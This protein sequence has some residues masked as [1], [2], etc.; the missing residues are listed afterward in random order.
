MSTIFLAY[1]TITV[2]G[3]IAMVIRALSALSHSPERLR[4]IL[5]LP[6][7]SGIIGMLYSYLL[8]EKA[9]TGFVR[10]LQFGFFSDLLMYFVGLNILTTVMSVPAIPW[11]LSSSSAKARIWGGVFCLCV[12]IW[13]P[14]CQEFASAPQH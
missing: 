5:I 10:L 7:L 4:A 6:M 3:I 1:V 12:A 2:I 11:L 8:A 13:L 9:F 14:F